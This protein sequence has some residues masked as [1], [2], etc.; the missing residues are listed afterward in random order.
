V[1]LLG[2]Y[3][4][5]NVLIA[6]P[7]I[8]VAVSMLLVLLGRLLCLC[9][10]VRWLLACFKCDPLDTSTLQF[11]QGMFWFQNLL[12]VTMLGYES[13]SDSPGNDGIWMFAGV[14]ST[15]GFLPWFWIRCASSTIGDRQFKALR[16]YLI[17]P[18]VLAFMS[19]W[20]VTAWDPTPVRDW[21]LPLLTFGQ[22]FGFVRLVIDVTVPETCSQG[23]DTPARPEGHSL[24][25]RPAR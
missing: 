21:A 5:T 15:C 12:G 3:L 9:P 19:A 13:S 7:G 4:E 24:S 2:R 16:S 18:V 17:Y 10:C 23:S 8:V 14:Q 6:L 22:I 25:N 20:L 11:M 1:F